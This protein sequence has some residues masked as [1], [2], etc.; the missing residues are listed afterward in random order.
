M[1]SGQPD[2]DERTL[3]YCVQMNTYLDYNTL[4]QPNRKELSSYSYFLPAEL[5]INSIEVTHKAYNEKQIR[6]ETHDYSTTRESP[7]Q[8]G[9]PLPPSPSL[10]S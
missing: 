6:K 2:V 1:R 7:Q 10:R 8:I 4:P 3:V 5:T 9:V